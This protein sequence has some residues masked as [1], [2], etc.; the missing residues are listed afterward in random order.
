MVEKVK[1]THVEIEGNPSVFSAYELLIKYGI[2]APKPPKEL[3]DES[4]KYTIY[5]PLNEGRLILL[6]TPEN[7]EQKVKLN[8]LISDRNVQNGTRRI[9]AYK[10][11]LLAPSWTMQYE[12]KDGIEVPNSHKQISPEQQIAFLEE[13]HQAEKAFLLQQENL[14]G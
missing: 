4:I 10:E 7:H 11:S 12:E 2:S 9:M 1:A 5:L 13:V 14:V 8:L 3:F 6:G